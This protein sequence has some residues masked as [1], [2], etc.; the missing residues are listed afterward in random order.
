M[1]GWPSG[2]FEPIR[3]PSPS[4]KAVG[5]QSDLVTGTPEQSGTS[6]VKIKLGSLLRLS[7]S[8]IAL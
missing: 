5:L 6:K 7:D 2:D 8:I 4:T 1:H 3:E